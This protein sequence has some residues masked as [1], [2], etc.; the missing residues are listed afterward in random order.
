MYPTS[1]SFVQINVE[2]SMFLFSV[3]GKAC[4]QGYYAQIYKRSHAKFLIVFCSER[5]FHGFASFANCMHPDEVI[6]TMKN[7]EFYEYRAGLWQQNISTGNESKAYADIRACLG[8]KCE[9]PWRGFDILS[10]RVN[11]YGV[12]LLFRSLVVCTSRSIKQNQILKFLHLT[13]TVTI[14]SKCTNLKRY[15]NQ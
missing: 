12:S 7:S 11:A 15:P 6:Q 5:Q 2:N 13:I 3:I 9:F 4:I 8:N 1:P 10:N 14:C